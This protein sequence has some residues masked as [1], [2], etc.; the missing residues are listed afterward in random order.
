MYTSEFLFR[1]FEIRLILK[2][3][4]HVFRHLEM[5]AIILANDQSWTMKK[6]LAPVLLVFRK[7]VHSGLLGVL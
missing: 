3:T 7:R 1:H 2:T 5:P 6:I 4:G